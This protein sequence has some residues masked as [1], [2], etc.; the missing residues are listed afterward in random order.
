[1]MGRLPGREAAVLMEQG[2]YSGTQL[3]ER[4][5][6]LT[7]RYRVSIDES[8]DRTS[9]PGRISPPANGSNSPTSDSSGGTP[10][11]RYLGED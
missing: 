4:T 1:M 10:D 3:F 8:L 9:E 5:L 11:E 2:G 6:A 7:R